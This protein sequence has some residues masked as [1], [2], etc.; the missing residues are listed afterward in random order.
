MFNFRVA[1][2]LLLPIMLSCSI[3]RNNDTIIGERQSSINNVVNEIAEDTIRVSS[4]KGSRHILAKVFEKAENKIVLFD[5]NDIFDVDY[6]FFIPTCKVIGN[7][8]T[9][10]IGKVVEHSAVGDCIKIRNKHYD[11]MGED[12]FTIEDLNFE[13][14]TDRTFLFSIM[15]AKDVTL[16]GCSFVSYSKETPACIHSLDL[17][18]NIH[19]ITIEDC[20]FVNMTGAKSGGCLWLRSFGDI[21][22]VLISRCSFYNNTTDEV[23]S[24]IAITGCIQDVSVVNSYFDYKRDA[25]CPFPNVFWSIINRKNQYIK[26]V[27]FSENSIKSNFVPS[28]VINSNSVYPIVVENN[29]FTFKEFLM[30]E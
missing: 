14:S 26:N 16:R 9:I 20:K 24:L 12:S 6:A 18:G 27:S 8:S 15:N 28:F 5:V 23:L 11:G 10:R 2:L 4:F 29:K 22:N 19:N 21:T 3:I 7:N 17:R 30:H 1:T 13:T 25:Y